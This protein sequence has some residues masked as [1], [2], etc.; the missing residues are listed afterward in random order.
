MCASLCMS[1]RACVFVQACAYVH[2]CTC[3]YWVFIRV[4]F[5]V[6]LCVCLCVCVLQHPPFKKSPLGEPRPSWPVL[7]IL[8][9]TPSTVIWRSGVFYGFYRQKLILRRNLRWFLFLTSDGRLYSYL[10][11]ETVSCWPGWAGLTDL[12][13]LIIGGHFLFISQI[14]NVVCGEIGAWV[15]TLSHWVPDA[16]PLLT[17]SHRQYEFQR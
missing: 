2:V 6:R 7:C 9:L 1:L 5:F 3:V 8:R 10:R 13:G 12:L 15:G 16:A 14:A 11:W 17:I 4:H